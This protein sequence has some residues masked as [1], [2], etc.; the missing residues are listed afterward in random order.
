[1]LISGFYD[2]DYNHM[3]SLE[4]LCKCCCHGYLRPFTHECC[5]YT[6]EEGIT[7]RYAQPV[8]IQKEH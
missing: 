8:Y 5:D 7:L 6:N 3:N 2:T 4:I 1:M